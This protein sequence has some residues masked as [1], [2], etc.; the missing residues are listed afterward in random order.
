[1]ATLGFSDYRQLQPH[2]KWI[3]VVSGLLLPLV[4][5]P[6]LGKEVRGAARWIDL[7]PVNFQPSELVKVTLVL[8]LA[9]I[10]SGKVDRKAVRESLTG[11]LR[12]WLIAAPVVVLVLLQRDLGTPVILVLT[13]LLLLFLAGART[14]HIAL[15][16]LA[17][18]PAG[19][20]LCLDNHRWERLSSF[21]NPWADPYDAGYQL[22]QS[23]ISLGKGGLWGVGLGNGT[24]KLFYLPDAHTDF[25]FS[26]MGEELGMAG[27]YVFLLLVL[28]FVVIGVRI[29][30]RAP[31]GFGVF[32]ACGLTFLVGMQMAI[33][34]AIALGMLPTKGMA[35]P[36][37]SY[38]GSSLVATMIA[39]GLLVS[40]ARHGVMRSRP[41][42]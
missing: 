24:Q 21:S 13:V 16:L 5:V 42:T 2:A 35:L 31:D 9:S 15:T 34:I 39:V 20:L 12:I 8:Y 30:L 26:V 29:A 11:Y 18:V 37:L 1:M 6:H 23:L 14:K 7:G 41:R 22:I 33:N 3:L 36:F 32:L 4:F 28:L 10:L 19:G 38:G 25:I 17:A 27:C 40:I